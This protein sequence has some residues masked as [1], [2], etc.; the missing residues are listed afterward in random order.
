MEKVLGFLKTPLTLAIISGILHG[1]SFIPFSPW[2]LAFCLTPLFIVWQRE[3]PIKVG[4]YTL[5]SFF[6]ASLIGYFWISHL[7][8][9]FVGFPPILSYL[10]CVVFAF[11]IHLQF[12]LAGYLWAKFARPHVKLPALSIAS[13]FSIIFLLFPPV[14]FPWSYAS[15]WHFGGFEGYQFGDIIGFKGIAAITIL[16]SGWFLWSVREKA[17]YRVPLVC[18]A[19]ICFHFFGFLYGKTINLGE[20]MTRV[21][22]AQGN[23]GNLQEMYIKHGLKYKEETVN[24]YLEVTRNGL[25]NKKA[26]F[27]IWPET[28]YPIEYNRYFSFS[29]YKRELVDFLEQHQAS[30]IT[31]VYSKTKTNKVANSVLFMD[32][33]GKVSGQPVYKKILLAF[34]EYIPLE[35]QFP[36]FRKWLPVAGN[37]ER[38]KSPQSRDLSGIRF[39][40]QICYEGLFPWF[41]RVLANQG[42]QVLVNHTNDSWYGPHSQ[43]LQHLYS[44][45]GRAVE[46]RTSLIRATNT[47]ISTL[48][49]PSGEVLEK[50]PL[51]KKWAKIYEVPYKQKASPT[52]YQKWGWA[53]PLPVLFILF[54]LSFID[55]KY[56]PRLGKNT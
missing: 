9:A 27:I 6:I 41:T 52:I 4:I 38:G 16:F 56:W 28:A 17:L 20:K 34:G 44:T 19:L 42:A 29:S 30:L 53:L 7:L 46:T 21:L 26:D 45:A 51:G 40:V 15:A 55:E 47:G 3:S 35:K 23:I 24:T 31:G 5:V 54:I 8:Q 33:S 1:T 18:F 50:S 10:A 39:G 11:L 43:P 14:I 32:K 2:A 25:K 22:I 36:I 49:L 37:F 12:G 48:I 13:F